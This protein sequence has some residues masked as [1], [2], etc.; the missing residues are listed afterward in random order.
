LASDITIDL[1]GFALIGTNGTAEGMTG[2]GTARRNISVRNGTVRN[3]STGVLLNGGGLARLEHLNVS[4]NSSHGM[5]MDAPAV[6]AGCSVIRNGGHGIFTT[7]AV[8]V[9]RGCLISENGLDGIRVGPSSVV[10]E[11]LCQGKASS[12]STNAGIRATSNNTGIENNDVVFYEN[13]VVVSGANNFILRNTTAFVGTN[14]IF[15]A[16]NSFG[17]TNTT[18]G[19]VIDHPWAN[20]A[21]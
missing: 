2:G 16:G 1:N 20:F 18:S 17:P 9:I 21:E 14:Y 13:G 15:A 11:N 5:Q 7:S 6:V 4:G 8:T 10:A 12:G 3:W 19:V